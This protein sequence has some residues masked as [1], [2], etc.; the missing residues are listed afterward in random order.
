MYP[1][2]RCRRLGLQCVGLG[3]QRYQFKDEGSKI[4]SPSHRPLGS[5][6]HVAHA[7]TA[8]GPSSNLSNSTT[9]LVS[10]F[11]VGIDPSADIRFQLAWNFGV[12]IED[13]PRR[14]GANEALDAASDAIVT[15]YTRYRAGYV[16]N[17]PVVLLKHSR[18][19]AALGRGLDTPAVAHSSETLCA[20]MLLM[21]CQVGI[22]Q[23][24]QRLHADSL[25]G[26]H[27]RL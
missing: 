5:S 12:F 9:R 21:T 16:H 19:L 25:L 8:G 3:Q 10:A 6:Q 1:C 14:L 15:A 7:C 4:A 13:V 22:S 11:V 2:P 18:A 27:R 17:H 20:M 24:F 23:I 26:L